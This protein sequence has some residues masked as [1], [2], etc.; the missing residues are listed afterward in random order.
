MKAFLLA[1]GE[2]RRLRPLTDSIPKCLIPI[3]KTVLLEIWLGLCARSGITEV[4]INLHAHVEAVRRF[5]A[6]RDFGVQIRLFE[7]P[8]LLGSAGT[9]AANLAWVQSDPYFWVFY[10]DVLT[11]LNVS[12]MLQAHLELNLAATLGVYQAPN[13]SQC[14][15]VQVDDACII[16]NFEE[17]PREPKSNLAFSG[18]MIGTSKFL[19]QIP[20]TLPADIGF[21]VL[22]KLAGRMRAYLSHDYLMD[23]GTLER[24]EVAQRTWPGY[25]P[26]VAPPSQLPE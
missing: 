6:N 14:G 15:I 20:S 18:V 21:D 9:I 5:V 25:A 19:R 16:R 23:I 22:P 4:L 10:A 17:K 3:R 11:N 1:A 2:G 24:Y 26:G 12:K 13:P 7:E 8:V